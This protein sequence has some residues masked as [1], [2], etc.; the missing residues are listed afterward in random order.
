MKFLENLHPY[1]NGSE[2]GGAGRGVVWAPK[3]PLFCGPCSIPTRGDPRMV[4]IG[5]GL[6]FWQINHAH[7]AYFRLFLGYFRVI[8]ATW[9]PPFRSQP[10]FLHIL[11]P[12]KY[13][14][15]K[16]WNIPKCSG[17]CLHWMPTDTAHWLITVKDIKISVQLGKGV[18]PTVWLEVGGGGS[19]A[20]KNKLVQESWDVLNLHSNN[21]CMICWSSAEGLHGKSSK[22][23]SNIWREYPSS[24]IFPHKHS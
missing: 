13:S 7:S 3:G 20:L 1:K 6:P 16:S 4:R 17:S 18:C 10:P 2:I 22:N 8:S 21:L 12:E 5:T 11:D 15:Y 9:P 19:W 23:Y 24:L 14:G